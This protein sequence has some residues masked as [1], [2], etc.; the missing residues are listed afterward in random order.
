MQHYYGS[1]LIQAEPLVREGQDGYR[2]VYEDGYQSW[3]P[4]EVFEAAY[5]PVGDLTGKEPWQQ[6][7][8]CEFHQNEDRL[9]KLKVA[10]ERKLVTN[11]VQADLMVQQQVVME[12]LR[13]ILLARLFE[14][15]LAEGIAVETTMTLDLMPQ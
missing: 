2:V 4:K 14:A 11:E 15:D 13:D 1:K 7:L 12:H 3:S 5:L 9:K 8:L 10:N 6:R